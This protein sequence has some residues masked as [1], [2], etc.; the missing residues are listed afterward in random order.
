ML[1]LTNLTTKNVFHNTKH[2]TFPKSSTN[3]SK[4]LLPNPADEARAKANYIIASG[5]TVKVK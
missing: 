3:F 5:K 1:N 4:N 2:L